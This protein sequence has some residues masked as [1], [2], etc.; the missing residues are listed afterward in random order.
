MQPHS[1]VCS[2]IFTCGTSRVSAH[3]SPQHKL[4]VDIPIHAD[5][6]TDSLNACITHPCITHPQVLPKC[7]ANT[8]LDLK[9]FACTPCATGSVAPLGAKACAVCGRGK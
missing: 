4:N 8:L 9:T 2:S 1:S 7:G 5:T 3:E 6:S